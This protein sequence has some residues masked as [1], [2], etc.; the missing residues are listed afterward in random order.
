MSAFIIYCS[1][2]GNTKHVAQVIGK[3]VNNLGHT[4]VML[5]LGNTEDAAAVKTQISKSSQ[6]ILLFIGSPVYAFHAVP[7]V[8]EFY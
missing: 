3:T 7:P 6:D 8:M 5:D 1:P 2:A 4:T